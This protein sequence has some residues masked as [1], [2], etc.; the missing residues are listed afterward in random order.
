MPPYCNVHNRYHTELSHGG[1][2]Y[3]RCKK[4]P[5]KDETSKDTTNEKR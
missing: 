4:C 5:P 1:R 3:P 2:G